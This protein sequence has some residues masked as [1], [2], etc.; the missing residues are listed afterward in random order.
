MDHST[1]NESFLL[2]IDDHVCLLSANKRIS[3]AEGFLA[4]DAILNL[5]M[6]VSDGLVV[7]EKVIHQRLMAE[8]PFMAT[9][10]ILMD[11]VKR[12]GDR[13]ALH[14]RIR[15][16]SMEAAKRVKAEG[17]SN[18][19]LERIAADPAFDTDLVSLQKL[20]DPAAFVGMAPQQTELFLQNVV[21]PLLSNNDTDIELPSINV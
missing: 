9:E 16:H 18:D 15:V 20:M 6:N 11:A 2:F 8:L 4:V 17:L 1:D 21:E 14:E 13:Q 19:L 12:G 5:V 3:I 10:N 7:Y